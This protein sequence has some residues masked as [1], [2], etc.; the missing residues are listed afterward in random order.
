MQVKGVCS[1]VNAVKMGIDE[2]PFASPW[3]KEM[4]GTLIEGDIG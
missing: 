2:K 4:E 1:E 3:V